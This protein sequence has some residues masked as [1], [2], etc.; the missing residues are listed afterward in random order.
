MRTLV[1]VT[2]LFCLPCSLALGEKPESSTEPL[3]RVLAVVEPGLTDSIEHENELFAQTLT[4][5]VSIDLAEVTLLDAIEQLKE[6]GG[7]PIRIDRLALEEWGVELDAKVTIRVNEVS[8]Y[9]ALRWTLK[10]HELAFLAEEDG[11][12]V[13]PE[14]CYQERLSYHFYAVPELIGNP[15]DHD[16]LIE[17]VTTVVEP[18]SWEELGGPDTIAPFNNGEMVGQTQPQQVRIAR[19]FEHLEALQK[20]P[21]DPYPTASRLVS[22][23]P[24]QT[25]AIDQALHTKRM[26][27]EFDQVPLVDIINTLNQQGNITF[28]LDHQGL[29]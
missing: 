1:S 3:G 16:S 10:Q 17:T 28:Y 4:K 7:I 11:L 13:T 5:R 24:D 20:T 9:S 27:V 18:D 2:L 6:L 23:F 21:N 25:I 29:E 12:L 26:T 8:L 15:A 14:K 22:L 19:L